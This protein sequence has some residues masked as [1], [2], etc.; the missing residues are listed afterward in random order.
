MLVYNMLQ[1]SCELYYETKYDEEKDILMADLKAMI[2]ALMCS[3]RGQWI[4][5]EVSP[6]NLTYPPSQ[7]SLQH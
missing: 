4:F 7:A 5:A 1:L 3:T 2:G 6:L